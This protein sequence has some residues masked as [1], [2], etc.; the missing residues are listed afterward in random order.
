MSRSRRTDFLPALESVERRELA[1]ADALV[2]LAHDGLNAAADVAG[3][4]ASVDHIRSTRRKSSPASVAY[5]AFTLPTTGTTNVLNFLLTREPYAGKQPTREILYKGQTKFFFTADAAGPHS[6]T[7][8]TYDKT[9]IAVPTSS[10]S[11]ARVPNYDF[12][13]VGPAN[14]FKLVQDPNRP[15]VAYPAPPGHPIP[16]IPT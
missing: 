6:F 15:Y 14:L 5:V 13:Y 1:A 7:V 9:S 4:H 8:N 16:G 3:L 10:T 11:S 2:S 12:V